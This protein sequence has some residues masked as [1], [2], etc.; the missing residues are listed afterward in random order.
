MCAPALTSTFINTNLVRGN[1]C[2]SAER[3]FDKWGWWCGAVILPPVS[4]GAGQKCCST[5]CSGVEPEVFVFILR[6][7]SLLIK[8][9][10]AKCRENLPKHNNI[11]AWLKKHNKSGCSCISYYTLADTGFWL[12]CYAN[13][14]FLAY[15]TSSAQ[16]STVSTL[17][18]ILQKKWSCSAF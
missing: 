14:V 3:P 1:E 9:W 5:L 18:Y 8:M 10:I 16:R 12:A 2:M 11:N 7:L 15:V 6:P 13:A 17:F 4:G